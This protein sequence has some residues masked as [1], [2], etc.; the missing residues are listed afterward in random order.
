MKEVYLTEEGKRAI[1]KPSRVDW[2]DNL[3]LREVKAVV[4]PTNVP[5]LVRLTGVATWRVSLSVWWDFR[6]GFR[7][8]ATV[9]DLP[10]DWPIEEVETFWSRWFPPLFAPKRR[11]V[12]DYVTYRSTAFDVVVPVCAIQRME[13]LQDDE[14]RP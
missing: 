14:L 4:L 5:G 12:P 8:A 13:D 10:D 11:P 7:P 9:D 6:Y 3:W 1:P 2:S